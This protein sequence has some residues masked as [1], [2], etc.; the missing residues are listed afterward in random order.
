MAWLGAFGIVFVV[1]AQAEEFNWTWEKDAET[2]AKEAP[3]R[4]KTNAASQEEPFTWSWEKE[5]AGKPD[6]KGAKPIEADR[7]GLGKAAY[8]ELIRDNLELR[9]KIA[10][11]DQERE[12]ARKRNELLSSEV[13]D[14]EKRIVELASQIQSLQNEKA[15]DGTSLDRAAQLEALLKT[16]QQEKSKLAGDVRSLRDR[17]A[18]AEAA[19][20]RRA[21]LA[22]EKGMVKPD[23][24][25]FRALEKENV[26]LKQQLAEL[27]TKRRMAVKERE[28]VALRGEEAET[29]VKASLEKQKDLNR[30]LAAAKVAKKQYREAVENLAQ[31]L[32]DM[33]GELIRLRASV[34]AKDSVLN[35]KRTELVALRTELQRREHRLAKAERMAD[36]LEQARAEVRQVSNREKRDMHYNMGAVYAKEGRYRDAEREYLRALRVD[37]SD[38]DVHHNL[39]ILYDD[40][41]K[42]RRRAIMHYERYLKLRPYA[43]DKDQVKK[44]LLELDTEW[45]RR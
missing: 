3:A 2:L 17:I 32:P 37:P 42:D 29:E 6:G 31:Q 18:S 1:H 40:N 19:R 39:G 7:K 4:Q 36:L 11:A 24:D 41:L 14:R 30:Q 10:E 13:K 26:G 9:K 38:P 44:W 35:A 5:D 12:S 15:S 27:E 23:S 16:A 8:E 45:R 21:D 22:R 43:A 25:L 20:T 28:Q 34:D 33:E